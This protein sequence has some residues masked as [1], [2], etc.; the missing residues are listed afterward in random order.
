MERLAD[1]RVAVLAT[2]GFQESELKE[3]VE[4]LKEAGEQVTSFR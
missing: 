4:V 2:D 3:P 1:F